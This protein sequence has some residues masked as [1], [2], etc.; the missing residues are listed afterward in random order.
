M[1]D[2]RDFEEKR[3]VVITEALHIE[4]R[5]I[6]REL[7]VGVTGDNRISMEGSLPIRLMP[8]QGTSP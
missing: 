3:Q 6:I 1:T 5:M 7:R 8:N 4:L 2:K